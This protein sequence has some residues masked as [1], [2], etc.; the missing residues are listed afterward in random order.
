MSVGEGIESSRFH[1]VDQKAAIGLAPESTASIVAAWGNLAT[2]ANFAQEDIRSSC[3][4]RVCNFTASFPDQND[5]QPEC[6]I[7]CENCDTDTLR[8]GVSALSRAVQDIYRCQKL[9]DE[10]GEVI[11]PANP[12]ELRDPYHVLTPV[13][14]RLAEIRMEELR[15]EP[16]RPNH[17]QIVDITPKSE[18]L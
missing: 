8:N 7:N 4:D 6:L 10:T 16:L 5:P 17:R 18:Y 2:F 12:S 14:A 13:R 1:Y 11:V 15:Q 9:K 3:S